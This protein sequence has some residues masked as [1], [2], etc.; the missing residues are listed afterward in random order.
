MNTPNCKSIW[1]SRTL[2]FNIL[3]LL[4]LVLNTVSGWS[5]VP[6]EYLPYILAAVNIVNLILRFLTTSAVRV[7]KPAPDVVNCGETE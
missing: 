1:A 2:W 4:L 5:E 7:F 3:S 6:P